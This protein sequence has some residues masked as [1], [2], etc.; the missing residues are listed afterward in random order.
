[1]DIKNLIIAADQGGNKF[2]GTYYTWEEDT[3]C[4]H[5]ARSF[6]AQKQP[7]VDPRTG[8]VT[9]SQFTA[10]LPIDMFSGPVPVLHINP[11]SWYHLKDSPDLF[12]KFKMLLDN[13]EKNEQAMRAQEAG[14]ILPG[15]N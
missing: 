4:M 7:K 10:I 9:I 8:Q 2:I 15:K 14:I 5:D 11:S 1:M 6:I 12:A 13:A 3:L